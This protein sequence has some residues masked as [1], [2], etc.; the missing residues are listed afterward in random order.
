[1][2]NNFGKN[3]IKNLSSKY[4][5]KLRNHAKK[6]AAD[7]LKTSSKKAKSDSK[8]KKQQ[9]QLNEIAHKI[10]RASRTSPK[11]NSETSE[12]EILRERFI[13]PELRHKINDLTLMEENY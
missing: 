9:K 5:Q 8:N 10:T 7:A 13:P 11:N 2:G 12:E 1:M 4:S 6:S 3:T